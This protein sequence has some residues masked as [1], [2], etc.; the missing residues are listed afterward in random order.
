[1]KKRCLIVA[2]GKDNRVIGDGS[3]LPK[4]NLTDDKKF[5]KETTTGH[6]VIMGRKSYNSLP[7]RWKPLPNRTNIILTKNHTPRTGPP[8]NDGL[9]IAL[10]FWEA[11]EK[12]ERN[13]GEKI[14]IIGG[15]EI[16]RL[17]LNSIVFDEI[18]ITSVEGWFEGSVTFPKLNFSL[19]D[20]Y[21]CTFQ[22][23]F[24]KVEGR[25]SHPFSIHS[26]ERV[27]FA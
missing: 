14:F 10:S 25:N 12:A 13:L 2:I 8:K 24:E 5:F 9:N 26:Y 17:A 3:E 19:C 15:G 20:N 22:K 16:Y 21:K 6:V 23:E 1:M 11:M 18:H 4:W 7:E 27:H